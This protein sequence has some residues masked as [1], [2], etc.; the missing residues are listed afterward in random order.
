VRQTRHVAARKITHQDT[1]PGDLTGINTG[2]LDCHE[3]S[4]PPGSDN[5][6]PGTM[7]C[8][9]HA[10]TQLG[11]DARKSVR[12]LV[13]APSGSTS[14]KVAAWARSALLPTSTPTPPRLTASHP[15]GSRPSPSTRASRRYRILAAGP[16]RRLEGWVLSVGQSHPQSALARCP[17]TDQGALL[18]R[19]PPAGHSAIVPTHHDAQGHPPGRSPRN[20]CRIDGHEVS[21]SEGSDTC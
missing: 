9:Q 5:H 8:G 14:R 18:H 19:E 1:H 6:L 11:D 3:T 16:I 2:R 7:P 4:Q 12:G 21:Q 20:L 17:P 10:A 15:P 13:Q